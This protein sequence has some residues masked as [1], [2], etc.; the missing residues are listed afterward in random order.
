M[1]E[2]IVD[3]KSILQR[4]IDTIAKLFSIKQK[5]N[6]KKEKYKDDIYPMW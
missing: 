3:K 4:I 6:E 2:E 1:D 5:K